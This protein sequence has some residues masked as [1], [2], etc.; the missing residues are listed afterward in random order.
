MRYLVAVILAFSVAVPANAETLD[1]YLDKVREARESAA[2][3]VENPAL[4]ESA[5]RRL[6]EIEGLRVSTPDGETFTAANRWA[7]ELAEEIR[8]DDT[9]LAARRAK[10]KLDAVEAQVEELR[11]GRVAALDG[12]LSTGEEFGDTAQKPAVGERNLGIRERMRRLSDWLSGE[13]HIDP[14]ATEARSVSVSPGAFLFVVLVLVGVIIAVIAY[15]IAKGR[16]GKSPAAPGMSGLRAAA[17]LENALTR[18]PQQWKELAREYFAKGD[19][20]QALRALYLSLLVVLHRRRLISY[21]TSKT[22]WEY[23]WELK[24]S[25]EEHKPF[26]ALTFAFD[27]KWYGR[28]ECGKE[29]YLRLERAADAVVEKQAAQE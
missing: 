13:G 18:T 15:Q 24:P 1:E 6:S 3:A 20:T 10:S 14:P 26:E 23:V 4:A 17:T 25:R 7:G 9:G 11:D 29:E 16:S 5:A 19:Y 28:E 8:A 2:A 21:D 27:Y 22:N 12:E